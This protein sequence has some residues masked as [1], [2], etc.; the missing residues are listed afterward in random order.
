MTNKFKRWKPGDDP[1]LRCLSSNG[2]GQCPYHKIPGL[3]YC[4]RHGYNSSE[5]AQATEV[6]RNYRLKRW[7]NR[8]NEFADSDNVKNLNEEIGILRMVMEEILNK[9]EDST[10]ILLFNHR[11]SDLAVK[12]E[13]LVIS[14]DKLEKGMNMVISKRAVLELA[15][16]Y[17]QIINNHITDDEILEII[18]AE[19]IETTR[20]L[21]DIGAN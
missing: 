13:K 8:V 16:N 11:I 21:E 2:N 17:I 15:T 1:H 5:A 10:D 7:Q 9:C 19:M 20:V 4:P 14:C 6:Q 3:Q 12:I 18:S